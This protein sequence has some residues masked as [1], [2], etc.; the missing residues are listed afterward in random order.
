MFDAMQEQIKS[1]KNLAEGIVLVE[2]QIEQI[3]K[4]AA[5]KRQAL[6]ELMQQT[7]QTAVT[8]DSGLAPKLE[9]RQRITKKSDVE[10]DTLF[11]WLNDNGL[12]DIIKPAVHPGTMQ[13]TLEA[14][15]AN[16][17]KLPEE[18]FNSFEQATVRFN[19]RSRFLA[20]KAVSGQQTAG[21][22]QRKIIPPPGFAGLPLGKEESLWGA[23][24]P[25]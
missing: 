16:G 15:I 11:V 22:G 25:N 21:S 13:T 9:I 5:E 3:E 12:G 24:K 18:L 17:G 6:I 1:I 23:R 14:F 4:D 7:G 8:L 2:A 19:G 10:N 20:N